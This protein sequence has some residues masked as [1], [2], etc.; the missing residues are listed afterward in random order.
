MAAAVGNPFL[1]TIVSIIVNCLTDINRLNAVK[2]EP[3]QFCKWL[4]FR[5]LIGDEKTM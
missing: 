5:I 4:V 1:S 2:V 3:S